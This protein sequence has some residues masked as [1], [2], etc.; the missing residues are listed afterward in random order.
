LIAFFFKLPI[1]R[2]AVP[3]FDLMKIGFIGLGRMG[4]AMSRRL[5]AGGVDMAVLDR[6][7]SLT[8]PLAALGAR[9]AKDVED[10]CAGC[11]VVITMLPSDSALEEVATGV[12]GLARFM[13]G[14]GVHVVCGTHGVEV[15]ERLRRA[16]KEHGQI[17]VSCTVLGRP[18]RAAEGKL[19]LVLAGPPAGV[20]ALAPV[21]ALLGETLFAA[22]ENP[23]SAVAVKIANNF[24]LGCAIEAI[25]EG[26]ALVRRYGVEAELFYEVLTQGLFDCVAYRAY[27]DVIAKQDWGRVGAT[28]AIGLKDA[29]LAFEAADRVCVPLPSGDVWRGHL[30]TAC[31]RGENELDWSVMAREQ[32]RNSGLE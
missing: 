7:A 12:G 14:E 17:L 5:L 23:L 3:E 21:L 24:V 32:F 8:A 29:Q 20:E 18:D 11:A 16:H 26:M 27:G 19:G 22:G 2:P 30:L 1:N 28:A 13:P 10:L 31:G 4:G 9:V 25:G 15:M 6:D